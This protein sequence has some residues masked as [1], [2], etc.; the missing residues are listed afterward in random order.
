MIIERV[1]VVVDLDEESDSE[2]LSVSARLFADGDDGE[3][4]EVA[5]STMGSGM[6]RRGFG[7]IWKRY[8]RPE[9][10]PE[11]EQA[12]LRMLEGYRVQRYDVEDAVNQLLG[13]DPEQHR[14]PRLA[15]EPLIELLA[16]RGVSVT[17]DK[18]IAMPFVFEFSDALQAQFET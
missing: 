18:L 14:P 11:D 13:R 17:E 8:Q 3:R 5:R 16:K 12:Q 4:I 6:W 15:W 1:G 9:P 2:R 10:L 7:A